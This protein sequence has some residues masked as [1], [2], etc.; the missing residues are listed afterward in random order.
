MRQRRHVM[1]R[2]L[3]HSSKDLMVYFVILS[4][5]LPRGADQHLTSPTGL[6][7]KGDRIADHRMRALQ[8][9]EF[10]QLV[11][12][13]PWISICNEQMPF[14]FL[15]FNSGSQHW[16]RST[17]GIHDYGSGKLGTIG[18]PNASVSHA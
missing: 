10:N 8:I 18:K 14:A 4:T 2:A 15:D 1:A 9:S 5:V 6:H 3:H 12:H 11:P 13:Q 7:V 17:G 16:R